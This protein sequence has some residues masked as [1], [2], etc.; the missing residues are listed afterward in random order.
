MLRWV[1]NI[2][3][4]L[5]AVIGST[6]L[7]M[8]LGLNYLGYGFFLASSVASIWLLWKSTDR[9]MALVVQSIYFLGIN[10]VGLV[11]YGANT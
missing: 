4:V 2:T 1:C 11:R 9:P 5:G 3:S 6:L 8:N 10:V 7:A